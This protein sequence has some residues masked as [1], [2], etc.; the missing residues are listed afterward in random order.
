MYV[1][2]YVSEAKHILSREPI[3]A[4]RQKAI[5]IMRKVTA[6]GVAAMEQHGAPR[7]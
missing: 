3:Q 7:R 4:A 1:E 6:L 5:H 2:D